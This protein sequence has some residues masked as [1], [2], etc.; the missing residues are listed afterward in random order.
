MQRSLRIVLSIAVVT[1]A[2]AW[3]SP[4][5]AVSKSTAAKQRSAAEIAKDLAAARAKLTSAGR[6]YDSALRAL[7]N[8]GGKIKSTDRRIK[9]ESQRLATAEALLGERVAAMYRTN[10][11]ANAMTFLLGATTFDDF[12]T[13]ADLI[14]LIGERDATLIKDVK[15]T[16]DRLEASR[17]S[18]QKSRSTQAAQL[19]TFKS[20]RDALNSQLNAVQAK[21][22]RLLG[23]LAAAMAREKAAGRITWAP[24][25]PNGMVFPVRG[26]NYY[27][28]TWGAP[29]S[30]GRRHM[31]TDVMAKRGTPVVAVSSGVVRAHSSGLGGLSI[32]LTGDNGWTYYYAHLNG[33]AVRSGHVEAG[34]LIGYVGNTGNARGGAC[35]LHFQMGPH[36]RWVNPYGYLRQMQ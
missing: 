2:L 21:Y 15:D 34:R 12:I 25:G 8:T 24:K 29:R 28:N 18:L 30:G 16:R 19:K 17:A 36:G 6:A 23:E 13:R 35:H 22:S 7:D 3:P 11:D 27:S 33:Y 32:T 26:A 5:L 4:V 10:D 14:E 20:K 31:G 1:L 9:Q